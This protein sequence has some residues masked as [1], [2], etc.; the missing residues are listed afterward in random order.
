MASLMFQFV[1]CPADENGQKAGANQQVTN[2]DLFI[3]GATVKFL[4]WH[5]PKLL[6][7]VSTEGGKTTTT[8]QQ[9]AEVDTATGKATA[10]PKHYLRLIAEING[11][12]CDTIAPSMFYQ[13]KPDGEGGTYEHVGEVSKAIKQ[14]ML[15][16]TTLGQQGT[17]VLAALG[18]KEYRLV[19]THTW[20]EGNYQRHIWDLAE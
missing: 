5:C 12:R 19:A 11:V 16:G 7:I 17:A 3:E 9:V 14:A 1:N 8:W 18:D 20:W 2:N 4:D 6:K 10:K 15:S 13:P